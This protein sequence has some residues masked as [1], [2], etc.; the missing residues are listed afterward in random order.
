M[1]DMYY[2]LQQ[3]IWLTYNLNLPKSSS[4]RS[5]YT[6]P[7]FFIRLCGILWMFVRSFSRSN[8]FWQFFLVLFMVVLH[9]FSSYALTSKTTN[10]IQGSAP[11]LIFDEGQIRAIN[12]DGLLGITL[13]NGTQYSPSNN[14]SSITPI[15]LPI[16]GQSFADIRMLVPID[17]DS[18]ALS[19][20]IGST[21]NYGENNDGDGDITATGSLNLS[22]VDKNN[23]P[24]SRSAVPDICNAPYQVKLA[25]TKGT[26]TTRYGVP[27][28]RS[29]SASNVTYYINPKAVP[30]V[31]FARPNLNYGSGLYAGPTEIWNNAKGFLPQ[32]SYGLNFPTTGANGL[33]FDLDI[34]GGGPLTWAPVSHGGITATMT[35]SPITTGVRVTLTGP[36][37]TPSQWSSSNPSR[38]SKPTLPQTFELIGRDSNDNPVVKYK[39]ELK[40][41][42]VNRGTW[43]DTYPS[44]LSWC[45]SFG[46]RMVRVK[47]LTNATC[48]DINS[49]LGCQ[50]SVGATPS[51][52]NNLYQRR[53]GAGFL[54]EW[55]ALH[56]YSEANFDSDWYWTSDSDG[57]IPFVVS[58]N[59]GIVDSYYNNH[60][61]LCASEL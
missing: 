34:G 17:V 9:P 46:Y 3:P 16:E 18:V 1:S 12:I 61:G 15:V 44:T 54:T 43:S 25:S 19:A 60:G 4:H 22:I 10:I 53:I 56:S 6:K 14:P 23:Q 57:S 37:A 39:F 36:V 28:S 32:S 40:Q 26:L 52:P 47:D 29:F 13:S 31:C 55:G 50:G 45:N 41:W 20:L 48:R 38:I 27:G 2:N 33:Y 35:N 5:F 8:L 11:Y 42:F 49:F 58:A 30:K 21:Y 7:F 59:H 24:V 51:S